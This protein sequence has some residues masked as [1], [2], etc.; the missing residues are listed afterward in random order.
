MWV[1]GSLTSTL[2]LCVNHVYTLNALI[3]VTSWVSE[4]WAP[5]RSAGATVG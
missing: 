3:A 1:L 4:G 5:L 2:M